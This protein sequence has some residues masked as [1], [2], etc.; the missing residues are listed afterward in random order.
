MAK[1]FEAE[2]NIG[3]TYGNDKE[4]NGLFCVLEDFY[5]LFEEW[6]SYTKEIENELE[7]VKNAFLNLMINKSKALEFF[8]KLEKSKNYSE[9]LVDC[10]GIIKSN[11][12]QFIDWCNKFKR[13]SEE[14]GKRLLILTYYSEIIQALRSSQILFQLGYCFNGIGLLRNCLEL[15]NYLFCLRNQEVTEN[16]LLGKPITPSF[17]SK[18]K[19]YKATEL[20]QDEE[21]LNDKTKV[22]VKKKWGKDYYVYVNFKNGLN[23]SIHNSTSNLSLRIQ[24]FSIDKSD[25][26]HFIPISMDEHK[27]NYINYCYATMIM[28]LKNYSKEWFISDNSRINRKIQDIIMSYDLVP[29]GYPKQLISLI[30]YIY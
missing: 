1:I 26:Y 8:E 10:N 15:N 11:E 19:K 14:K 3:M 21:K 4:I 5:E 27:G 28:T 16:E 29:S 23:K 13:A 25:E 9:L 17:I 2:K 18:S 12:A 24:T 30:N 22:F 20:W 6:K 7:T